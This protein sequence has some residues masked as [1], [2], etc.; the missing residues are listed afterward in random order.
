MEVCVCLPA[1]KRKKILRG[2]ETIVY[3]NNNKRRSFQARE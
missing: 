1:V 3:N 2:R